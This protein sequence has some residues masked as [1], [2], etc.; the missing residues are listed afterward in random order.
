MRAALGRVPVDVQLQGGDSVMDVLPP[1]C[2]G[3]LLL[4]LL[5]FVGSELDPAAQALCVH[6]TGGVLALQPLHV[7]QSVLRAFTPCSTA[8][9]L[10]NPHRVVMDPLV[11]P[12]PLDGDQNV[13]RNCFRVHQVQA[14]FAA[15][16]ARIADYC[17]AKQARMLAREA[18][19][20]NKLQRLRASLAALEAARSAA[21][22]GE[23]D[24]DAA[25]DHHEADPHGDDADGHAAASASAS[26]PST[27]SLGS[28]DGAAATKAVP[29]DAGADGA[30]ASSGRR[31]DGRSLSPRVARDIEVAAQIAALAARISAIERRE[32]DP[33]PEPEPE[34]D[35]EADGAKLKAAE[36]GD[37]A[38][39]KGEGQSSGQAD[40]WA[41][42]DESLSEFPLLSRILPC[43]AGL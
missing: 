21:S 19:R 4:R 22:R 27:G 11:L 35:G 25:S 31:R 23:G 42:D 6:A 26:A 1:P 18:A 5:R 16:R 33:E 30:A 14:S 15:A 8:T 43:L 20:R 41:E 32:P 24:G 29:T 34:A 39:G 10:L 28:E 3:R 7:F 36:P 17:A 38:G 40:D 2:L 13:G 37:G 9:G 12:D